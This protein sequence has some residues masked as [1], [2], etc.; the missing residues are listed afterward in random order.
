M[1]KVKIMKSFEGFQLQTEWEVKDGEM[2]VLFGPSGSGKSLSIRAIAGL[3]KP[4]QGYIEIDQRLVFHSHRG[5]DVPA[6]E[7]NVGYVPQNYGLFPH[8]TIFENIMFGIKGI[9]AKSRKSKTLDLLF[10]VGLEDKQNKYPRHL[11]GG[12]KQRAAL[13][14][15]LAFNPRA[16]LLDEPFS[17]VDIT[18]RDILRDEIK[19]ILKEWH[20]PIVLVTHDPHDLKVMATKVIEYGNGSFPSSVCLA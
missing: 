20:I 13:L 18:V 5:I 2:A 4:D 16:L 1:L 3:E 10:R 19:K 6:R 15:A 9:N 7:R 12:E 14:R 8:M 11:S 17:A